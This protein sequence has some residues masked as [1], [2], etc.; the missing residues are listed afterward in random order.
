MIFIS[1]NE[2]LHK[3]IKKKDDELEE[4]KECKSFTEET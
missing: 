1:Q 2:E 3:K 4:M